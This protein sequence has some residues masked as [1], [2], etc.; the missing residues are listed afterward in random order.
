M[1]LYIHPLPSDNPLERSVVVR[2]HDHLY[3]S[4]NSPLAFLMCEYTETDRQTRSLRVLLRVK[5]EV[6]ASWVIQEYTF[7]RLSISI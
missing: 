3:I 5:L 4:S 7:F 6:L 1:L 2:R